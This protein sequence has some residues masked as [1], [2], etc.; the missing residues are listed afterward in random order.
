MRKESGIRGKWGPK[1]TAGASSNER[2]KYREDNLRY[3]IQ[4]IRNSE[5]I[6][7]VYPIHKHELRIPACAK[8]GAV[9]DMR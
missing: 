5:P 8:W 7:N 1:G 9:F 2:N 4:H 6:A 3:A